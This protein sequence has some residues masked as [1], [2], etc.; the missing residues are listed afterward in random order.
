[1]TVLEREGYIVQPHT[2]AGRVPTD[3]GY[4]FFVDHF[5]RQPGLA[6]AQRRVVVRL[7][8]VFASA[9][10][11]LEDLLHET[12]QLARP[13]EHA[14]P[15]WSS[16][17]QRRDGDACAACSS[18]QPAA[19]RWCSRSRSSPTAASRSACCTSPPTSTTPPSP[20]PAR[21]STPSSPAPAGRRPP[22]RRRPGRRPDA[23]ALATR[24]ARRAAPPRAATTSVEPLYVGGASRL[25]AEQEAFPDV[26]QRGPPARAARAPG[27]GGVA[28]AR[29]ARP[30]PHGAHR[31]REPASTSCAT[32]RSSSRPTRV[33]GEVAG[34]VGVLGPTR[35]DYRQAL[36]AVEAISPAAR[37]RA[38]VTP[39]STTSC[40]AS[41]ATPPTTR[42]SAPTAR[43]RASTTPT[44]TPTIPRP[45]TRFKEISVA[46][47]TLRDPE[48]RRR[49]D[50]FGEDGA[51][52]RG[53]GGPARRRSASATSSTRSS[54]ATR[55]ATRRGPA[56]PPRAP[57]AE[58]VV[59]LDLARGRV[60]RHR[61]RRDPPARRVRA[62]R[63]LAAASPA[64][65]PRAATCAAARAR[66]A[67]CAARSSA[68]SS[69]RRRAW[70][71]AP[72]AAASPR[73]VATAAATVA[74]APSKSID[75]EVPAGVDDGQRLRLAGR[76]PAAP[77][78]GVPGDLYVTVRVAPDPRFE[79]QGDDLLHVRHIAF[80]QAALGMPPRR[81]DPRRR[82]GAGRAAGHPARPRVPSEGPGRPAL[83][84]RGRGDLLVRVDV[85]VPDRLSAEEDELLRQLGR[86]RAARRSRRRRT[87][88]C[89]PGSRPRSSSRDR[90]AVRRLPRRP[91][92]ARAGRRDRARL[93]RPARRPRRRRRATTATTSSASRRVRA[94]R[95]RHR[96]RRLRALARVRRWPAPTRGARARRAH[97]RWSH[98]PHA[99]ARASPSRVRSPR[100]RSPS[101]R[102]RSSP[103]SASTASCWCRRRARWC[104]GTTPRA[105][106]A[107]DAAAARGPRGG[108]AVPP[109]PGAR[110]RRPGRARRPRPASR[111]RRR[112]GRRRRP[113]PEL[114]LPAGGEWLVAVGP[115]GGFDAGRARA[116]SA[117]RPAL[118]GRPLRPAGR[119][120]GDR[121]A[122]PR[123]AGRR[124]SH[125]RSPDDADRREW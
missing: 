85:D 110:G 15:P 30:G 43:W 18:C 2:S 27:R 96:R 62:L 95:A 31:L 54:A 59:H 118:G 20:P 102:C 77:R 111:P 88:A 47:E 32:A 12:S 63:G 82:R 16:G 125:R 89:S 93:R 99:R 98:E 120:R 117:T 22:R 73:R 29:P 124:R 115:E 6:P 36:A 91:R 26:H 84:G 37:R 45:R 41:P 49:Y 79:R 56:G 75:V 57:D 119:D 52:R 3:R 28:R 72:P 70:R 114:R 9:H 103:S 46:Y 58:A 4:R 109:R 104:A 80:T 17:P 90:R 19:R 107:L 112:R 10:R 121:G 53:G 34:T 21:C 64:P 81:R 44:A 78:G 8:H 25:A 122:P 33:D 87:R 101:S 71:A 86:A 97:R 105:A 92:L 50:V 24:G 11:V 55:S 100:A 60:R 51:R 83:R 1:M 108:A 67:R 40:S 42:S 23:D 5:E 113:P 66:S 35:M 38:L 65:T 48:R 68:R 116:A 106:A 39:R 123:C 13:G 76:G 14:T 94:G 7:L 74:C 61:D 69:P